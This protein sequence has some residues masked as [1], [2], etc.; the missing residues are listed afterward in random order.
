MSEYKMRNKGP[1][2]CQY[3]IE[4]TTWAIEMIVAI[5]GSRY[6]LTTKRSHLRSDSLSLWGVDEQTF[7][8]SLETTLK[9]MKIEVNQICKPKLFC[10]SCFSWETI[11]IIETKF[12]FA[13]PHTGK[14]DTV[15]CWNSCSLFGNDFQIPLPIKKEDRR[16]KIV[17]SVWQ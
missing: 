8:Y 15:T 13:L 2:S 11:K 17:K 12:I 6:V 3:Y 1:K 7:R 5:K 14:E 9:E 10:K 4:Q 16:T